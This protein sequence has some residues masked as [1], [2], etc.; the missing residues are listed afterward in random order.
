TVTEGVASGAAVYTLSEQASDAEAAALARLENRADLLAGVDL[1]GAEDGLARVLLDMAQRET[2]ARSHLLAGE[3]VA[4]LRLRVGVLRSRPHRSAGFVVLKAPDIP[5]LLLE[6]GF[7]SHAE[8]RANMLSPDWRREAAA[9]V[10]AALDA[11]VVADRERAALLR[12]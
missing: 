6:L 4:A 3:L 12:Q 2:D 11:W 7:L 1:A 10:T 5:S 9:A 8:D